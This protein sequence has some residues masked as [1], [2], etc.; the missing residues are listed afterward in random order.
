MKDELICA[1][2]PVLV[3]QPL[4]SDEFAVSN[5]GININFDSFAI[6]KAALVVVVGQADSN[7]IHPQVSEKKRKFRN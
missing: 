3:E 5:E 1:V 6:K 2:V 7:F 4:E